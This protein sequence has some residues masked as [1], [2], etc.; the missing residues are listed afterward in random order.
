[1]AFITRDNIYGLDNM[2]KDE[3]GDDHKLIVRG[4]SG[5][6][7]L[8]NTCYMNAGLQCLF[9]TNILASYFIDKQFLNRLKNNIINKLAKEERRKK[10]ITDDVDI[11]LN[12]SAIL[13]NIKNTISY[14]FYKT[15][16]KWLYNNDTIEPTL[17]KK[18][19]GNCNPLFKGNL[20]NDSQELI[21]CIL[22]NIHEDLKC[23]V[24]LNYINIPD[25][26]INYRNN[27]KQYQ[28]VLGNPQN[29]DID[30]S[31]LISSYYKYINNH[32]YE[33]ITNSALEYWE[34]F[35]RLQH[36]IIRDIFTGL[37]YTETRCNVCNINS[38]SFE[39]FVMLQLAIPKS[40]ETV[41]LSDCLRN[42]ASKYMLVDK[43]QY[44]CSQCK[45]YRD[46]TQMTY[47]WEVPE[48][49]IIH[50]KRFTN[51]IHGSF[52]RIEKNSTKINF[53]LKDLDMND[54]ISPYNKN[55]NTHYDLYG[56]VQQH[57]S[58]NYGHYIS[59]CKNAINDNWYEFNDAHI[60]YVNQG[61]LESE[62]LAISAYILFYK[63]IYR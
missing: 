47:L 21:N 46:A 2:D 23:E 13:H 17:F 16:K 48:I 35:I 25:A 38:L 40:N 8:G 11:E 41:S 34:K 4:L 32:M 51:D 55:Q 10:N 50:L 62:N 30:K 27:I 60:T 49:L 37:S 19:I 1:M 57:G 12:K 28:T 26:I 22:D 9:A 42:H 24:Q 3:I 45:D 31:T 39:P 33:Y 63:K 6:K 5:L 53:P 29:S 44:Q 14:A 56:I 59:Y 61:K 7:N 52:C 58:L 18:I 43:N 15:V 36:S 54:Y 20:Q